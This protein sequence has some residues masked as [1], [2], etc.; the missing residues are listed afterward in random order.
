MCITKLYIIIH[1]FKLYVSGTKLFVSF[2]PFLIE[3]SFSF[4]IQS[5]NYSVI[6]TAM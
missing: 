5:K 6:L 2:S 4:S 1:V 3:C